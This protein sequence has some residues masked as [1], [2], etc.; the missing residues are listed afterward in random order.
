MIAAMLTPDPDPPWGA[1]A[2]PPAGPAPPPASAPVAP[3]DPPPAPPG[4]AY[5]VGYGQHPGTWYPPAP[6]PAG[7]PSGYLPPGWAGQPAPGASGPPGWGAVAP[8]SRRTAGRTRGGAAGGA[9]AAL[10]AFI[11]YAFAF[12][13]FGATFLT[14]L[15]AIVLYAQLFGWAFGVGIVV[16]IF[17]HEMG[18]FLVSWALGVPMSAPVFV[19]FLGAFTSAGR[20]FQSSRR[21]EAV[22]A[23]AGPVF[24]FLAT[25]AVYLWALAQAV[26][27]Q[28]VAFAFSLSYFGF[29]VTL[30]NLIPMVPLDGGRIASAISKWF[31]LAGLAVFGALLL[32]QLAGATLFNPFLLLIFLVGGYSVWH[33]FRA[34]RQ[35]REAPPLPAATRAVIGVGYIALVALSALLMSLST[36]WLVAHAYLSPIS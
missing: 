16:I 24:G 28:A 19:P 7:A 23:A 2:E 29:F 32:T 26:P 10:A 12:G 8:S 34:A 27:T 22:I 20:G 21:T 13:K 35:G 14:M 11:K 5:P 18:H 33:R 31:N 1:P 36:G 3:G 30:F 9:L 25:M 17:V 4:W 15:V 6:G